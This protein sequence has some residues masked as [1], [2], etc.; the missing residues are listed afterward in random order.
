[1]YEYS[2]NTT[3][4]EDICFEYGYERNSGIISFKSPFFSLACKHIGI[5]WKRLSRTGKAIL[6]AQAIDIFNQGNNGTMFRDEFD[7]AKIFI[8][9]YY[10]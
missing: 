10:K 9:N 1:M 7:E 4:S 8:E 3:Y 5:E 6:K 2:K